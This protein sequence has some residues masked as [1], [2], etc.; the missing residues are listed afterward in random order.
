MVVGCFFLPRVG[1]IGQD[2]WEMYG[3]AGAMEGCGVYIFWH[4]R[5]ND[6]KAL[7][8]TTDWPMCI[9][10]RIGHWRLGLLVFLSSFLY[11]FL[12]LG[13]NCTCMLSENNKL[14]RRL[15][16]A[17]SN[18]SRLTPRYTSIRASSSPQKLELELLRYLVLSTFY[19]KSS[20][21]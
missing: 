12:Y 17:T 3:S 18:T 16:F 5:N 20:N 4:F 8:E 19:L 11:Y 6:E 9:T 7:W 1:G 13:D 2:P 21:G 15:M 14:S 10:I